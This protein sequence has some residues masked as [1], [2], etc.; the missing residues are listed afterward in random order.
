MGLTIHQ[1]KI[2]PALG[3][4]LQKLC[5]FGAIAYANGAL[6]IGMGCK[7]CK[8]CVKQGE[9]VVTFEEDDAPQIDKS[10]YTGIAV[11]CEHYK[12]SIHA[13]T[14][15]LLGKA[16]DDWEIGS[17]ATAQFAAVSEI[18]RYVIGLGKK[19]QPEE[20]SRRLLYE[21]GMRRIADQERGLLEMMLEG[22]GNVPGLRRISGVVVRMDG[23][24][25][26]IACLFSH[27]RRSLGDELCACVVDV[28]QGL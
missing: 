26:R 6:S 24:L 27:G 10:E 23:K 4:K 9:G 12:G 3:E 14:F 16:R 17:P 20:N 18:V 11:F 5:P 25:D 19:I 28:E 13:V 1:E 7:L 15:E 22:T 8:L 2:T 21:A